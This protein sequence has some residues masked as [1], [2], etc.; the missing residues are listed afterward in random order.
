MKPP[1]VTDP[2]LSD[3][4]AIH[5][6]IQVARPPRLYRHVTFRRDKDI[7]VQDFC[8]DLMSTLSQNLESSPKDLVD[9]YNSSLT[10][11]MDKYAPEQTKSIHVRPNTQWYTQNL[12]EA[13]QE[14]RRLER[15]WRNTKLTV[16]KEMYRHQCTIVNNMLLQAKQVYYCNKLEECGGD[17][18][19]LHRLT[20]NLLGQGSET[21]LP[22]SNS[23]QAL[24]QKFCDFFSQ[25][26][27]KIHEAIGTDDSEDALASDSPFEGTPLSDFSPQRRK[28]T[29]SL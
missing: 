27:T 7:P 29:S 5:F 12:R 24:A 4:M 13:K 16:H 26:I 9:V 6:T 10:S 18:A 28:Y 8:S 23:P 17:Q 11:L 25:K 1:F 21:P 15:L 3:H 22:T 2:G 19:K 20:K 14:K